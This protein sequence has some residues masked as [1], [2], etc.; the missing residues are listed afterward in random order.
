MATIPVT[1]TREGWQTSGTTDGDGRI[2]IGADIEVDVGGA[3][4]DSDSDE[5][6]DDEEAIPSGVWVT[7]IARNL[8]ED[9]YTLQINITGLVTEVSRGYSHPL[10]IHNL[11]TQ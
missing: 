4:F 1:Q 11:I 6:T 10:T 9:V 2:L 7:A 3:G 5:E 8:D